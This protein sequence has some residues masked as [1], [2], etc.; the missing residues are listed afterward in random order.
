MINSENNEKLPRIALKN[1]VTNI[2]HKKENDQ[3]V[4]FKKLIYT[5][6]SKVN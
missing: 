6:T 4:S 1:S 2:A 3:N 5:Y